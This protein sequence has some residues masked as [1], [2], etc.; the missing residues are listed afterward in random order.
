MFKLLL[1]LLFGPRRGHQISRRERPSEMRTDWAQTR[2]PPSQ[3]DLGLLP[4]TEEWIASLP[5]NVQPHQLATRHR[6]LTNRL[7]L[8]W[9]DPDLTERVL[10][11]LLLDKRG[12]ERKGF[13]APVAAELLALREHLARKR[14]GS[15]LGQW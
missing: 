11:E 14:K 4:L 3:F 10:D 1:R 8:C 7:A 15:P 12:G 2:S 5:R 13:S 6:R 9:K